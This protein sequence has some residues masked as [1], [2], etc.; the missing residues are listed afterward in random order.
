[1]RWFA[2]V[3][4]LEFWISSNICYNF[5]MF[6]FYCKNEFIIGQTRKLTNKTLFSIFNWFWV[7]EKINILNKNYII[8]YIQN[9]NFGTL[10]NQRMSYQGH[11]LPN[12]LL[13]EALEILWNILISEWDFFGHCD[14]IILFFKYQTNVLMFFFYEITRWM[15]LL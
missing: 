15:Q 14:Y 11:N 5:F 2:N 12:L 4:K 3:L 7:V 1:M 9:S 13:Q 8:F 6:I 10:A